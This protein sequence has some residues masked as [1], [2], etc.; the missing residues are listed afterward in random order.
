MSAA[1]D[2]LPILLQGS[3]DPRGH[4]LGLS[5]EGGGR[6]GRGT[7]Q[8]CGMLITVDVLL[9]QCRYQGDQMLSGFR[10]EESSGRGVA[11]EGMREQEGDGGEGK[12][13]GGDGGD[14]S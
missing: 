14:P 8:Y 5:I 11:W 4:A 12:D 2:L 7:K 3:E 1:I 10:Y 9:V 6:A 13:G